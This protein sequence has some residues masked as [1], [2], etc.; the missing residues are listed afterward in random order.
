VNHTGTIQA[1]VM[2]DRRSVLITAASEGDILFTAW[3]NRSVIGGVHTSGP[4]LTSLHT[5][6]DES[7]MAV[8]DSDGFVSLWDLRTLDVPLLFTAPLA[9]TVP[10]HLAAVQA[11][12]QIA[13]LSDKLRRALEL[14]E[15]VMQY[16]FRYDIEIGEVPTIKVGEFDIEIG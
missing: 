6:P 2:L 15:R 13:D 14:L 3:D 1:V 4:R 16:R 9:K 8:S 12:K 11:A 7:F 10:D 5:S